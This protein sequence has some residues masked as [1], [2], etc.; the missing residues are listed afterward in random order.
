MNCRILRLKEVKSLTGL[1]RSTIYS[2]ILKGNFPKQVHLTGARSVGW[3]ENA[4]KE[5]IE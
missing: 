5:W 4:I 1:S 2:E 3:H